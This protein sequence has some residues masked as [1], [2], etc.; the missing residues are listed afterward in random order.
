ME[1]QDTILKRARNF[2][3][4]ESELEALYNNPSA[5]NRVYDSALAQTMTEE[6]YIPGNQAFL[7]EKRKQIANLPKG[8]IPAIN[9]PAHIYMKI[10]GMAASMILLIGLFFI[11]RP[12][13]TLTEVEQIN[14]FRNISLA[15]FSPD[16]IAS[17]ERS[18]EG[19]D[20]IDIVNAYSN[21]D[22]KYILNKTN[23]ELK[24]AELQLF[25]ARVLMNVDK[26]EDAY[27]IMN[28]IDQK[29]LVQKNVYFWMKAE[30]ALGV[31]DMDV[32]EAVKKSIID[33]KLPGY[34]DI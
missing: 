16:L 25:R 6:L 33:S 4:T 20:N 22:Y 8:T 29:E 3:L 27:I 5:I 1:N 30:A 14:K 26:Y 13:T 21:H 32:F 19:M 28:A 11:I 31:G 17:I 24:T 7:D 18:S 10:I 34:K 23:R 12:S 15:K 2:D 9:R